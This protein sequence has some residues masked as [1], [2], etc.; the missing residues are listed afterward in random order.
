MAETGSVLSAWA[1]MLP[2]AELLLAALGS[3]CGSRADPAE[4]AIPYPST[5]S[6]IGRV[7]GER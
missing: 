2:S 3:I 1:W 4:A 6:I 5:F 7:R